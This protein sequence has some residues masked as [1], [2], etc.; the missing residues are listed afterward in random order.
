MSKIENFIQQEK[1]SYGKVYTDLAY[2]ID[3]VSP[4][5]EPGVLNNRKYYPKIKVIKKYIELLN[6]TNTET[7]SKG[8]FRGF[9]NDKYI[10]LLEDYKKDNKE[11]LEVL[12]SCQ[13]CQCLNCVSQCKF[14]SCDGCSH[15]GK[16]AYCDKKRVSVFTY[17][18]YCI[19]LENQDTGNDDSYNVLAI[20]QDVLKDKRYIIIETINRDEKFVLYLFPETRGDRYE[21]ITNEEDFNFAIESYQII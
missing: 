6:S 15:Y 17:D 21:E 18:N 10:T 5:L 14:D 7:K 8:F 13:N 1:E 11:D 4:F 2:A 16:V 9:G 19:N 12:K 3:K 20:V